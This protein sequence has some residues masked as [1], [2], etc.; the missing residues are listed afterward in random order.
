MGEANVDWVAYQ[1][2]K[3]EWIAQ[4]QI[5]GFSQKLAVT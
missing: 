2:S 4:D 3:L 1:D 5:R